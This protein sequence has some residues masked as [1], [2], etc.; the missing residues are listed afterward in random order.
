MSRSQFQFIVE[1]TETLPYEA[2]IDTNSQYREPVYSF[3]PE[4]QTRHYEPHATP[5][6]VMALENLPDSLS[7]QM[8]QLPSTHTVQRYWRPSP[9]LTK[10]L[11][12]L[13]N[14]HFYPFP[15]ILC[16]QYG[17]LLYAERVS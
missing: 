12:R 14:D 5:Q 16:V 9:N 4:P 17:R 8:T 3:L 7:M 1:A 2:T 10:A 13:H 11:G 6:I 15:C